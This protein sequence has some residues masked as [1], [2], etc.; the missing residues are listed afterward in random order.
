MKKVKI[1]CTGTESLALSKFTE[2][3][4]SLKDLSDD[5]Y[6]R[7]KKSILKYG[8]SF[9]MFVWKDKKT[10]YIVDAHQRKKVL[11]RLEA[12]GYEIPALPTVFINAKDKKEAK[13]KL[14]Q[15][16]SNYGKITQ[17]GLYEF[18][19]EP[20]FELDFEELKLDIDLPD[21]D[22]ELFGGSFL[23]DGDSDSFSL[24]DGAKEPFQQI[25][26]TLAD[27]QAEFIKGCLG[28][29]RKDNTVETFGNENGNGN[30]IYRVAKEWEEQKV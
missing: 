10:N 17:D 30:A 4:G 18:L 12:E 7:L 25:T 8:F 22:M 19:N 16:N 27:A 24:P 15:L 11:K 28:L 26:F 1:E 23:N 9:P 14:L 6:E 3:Q 13:E 29:A 2:M 5:N 20:G 21:V